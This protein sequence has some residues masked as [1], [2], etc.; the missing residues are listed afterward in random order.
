MSSQTKCF[1]SITSILDK[2]E[3][4]MNW[5]TFGGKEILII[6]VHP[7]VTAVRH[8][9]FINAVC[10]SNISKSNTFPKFTFLAYPDLC[11]NKYQDG[12]L[13]KCPFID[14]IVKSILWRQGQG[15]ET[16]N[17]KNFIVEGK[18]R[19]GKIYFTCITWIT[20]S[21]KIYF[22]NKYMTVNF[23]GKFSKEN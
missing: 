4:E 18:G 17:T 22:A 5:P 19:W 12:R 16:T 15:Q 20:W 10:K 6:L 1:S 13:G 14:A 23:L 9:V 3:Q 21:D 2:C 8:C 7:S 11:S